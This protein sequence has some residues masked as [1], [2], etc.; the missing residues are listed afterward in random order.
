MFGE[1][2]PDEEIEELDD[3]K[4]ILKKENFSYEKFY[5]VE[6]NNLKTNDPLE[7]L[8]LNSGILS[9]EDILKSL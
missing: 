2:I 9:L 4:R 3:L 5:P 1:E 8:L 6:F 7:Q